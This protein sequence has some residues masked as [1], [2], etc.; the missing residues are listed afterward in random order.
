MLTS[1]AALFEQLWAGQMSNWMDG[2]FAG[3]VQEGFSVK[4]YLDG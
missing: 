1:P 3:M 4:L 2:H